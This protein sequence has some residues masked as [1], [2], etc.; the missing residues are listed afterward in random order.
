[1]PGAV[2]PEASGGG[3]DAARCPCALGPA[4]REPKVA[5][6]VHLQRG[7]QQMTALRPA[8]SKPR[9]VSLSTQGWPPPGHAAPQGPPC[10]GRPPAHET[11][12][13]QGP[14]SPVILRGRAERGGH[15]CASVT[16][17]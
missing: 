6:R 12:S 15:P 2:V 16:L 7:S 4:N 13:C 3:G 10:A 5:A 17:G 11:T 14:S 1:M 9:G 8:S